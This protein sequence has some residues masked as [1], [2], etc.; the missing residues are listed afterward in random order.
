[1]YE[2]LCVPILNNIQF[3]MLLKVHLHSTL[4]KTQTEHKGSLS[5]ARVKSMCRQVSDQIQTEKLKDSK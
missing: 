4:V 2:F 1:M 3:F 5:I